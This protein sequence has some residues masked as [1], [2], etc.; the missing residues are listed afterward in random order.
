MIIAIN[1]NNC[2]IILGGG[3]Q[4]N[5]ENLSLERTIAPTFS[6]WCR[7]FNPPFKIH[8]C[9]TVGITQIYHNTILLFLSITIVE[10]EFHNNNMYMYGYVYYVFYVTILLLY[11]VCVIVM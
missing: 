11:V 9:A 2:L 8:V 7:L 5:G 4:K 3:V 1:N 10:R 6:P